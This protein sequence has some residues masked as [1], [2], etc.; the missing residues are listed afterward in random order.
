MLPTIQK[1][2]KNE[3][4]SKTHRYKGNCDRDFFFFFFLKEKKKKGKKGQFGSF[5]RVRNKREKKILKIGM[6]PP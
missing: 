2:K 3:N 6:T 4:P 5:T 1:K